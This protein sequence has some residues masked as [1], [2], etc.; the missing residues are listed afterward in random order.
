ML[1]KKAKQVSKSFRQN[2]EKEDGTMINKD[3]GTNKKHFQLSATLEKLIIHKCMIDSGKN[4][5]DEADNV[6]H[7]RSTK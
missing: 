5:K 6:Q 3:N 2:K 7:R 4:S 1:M